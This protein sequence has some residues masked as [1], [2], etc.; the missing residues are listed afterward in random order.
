M[1]DD[2]NIVKFQPL[3]RYQYPSMPT[4]ENLRLW[5]GKLWRSFREPDDDPL[6]ADNS[7]QWATEQRLDRIAPPPAC[8]PLLRELEATFQE[9][10]SEPNPSHWTQL[11]VV[12]PCDAYDILGAWA[13]RY[14]HEVIEPP[15]RE[16]L[17]SNLVDRAP[18]AFDSDGVIVIPRLERWFIRHHNGLNLVRELLSQLAVLKRH[19]V[20][21][22]NSWAWRFLEKSIDAELILP[23]GMT[24]QAFD[25][26]RLRDW[27]VETAAE[28]GVDDLTFR[29][30]KD[31][32]D[33]LEF[34][35][36][37]QPKSEFLAVLAAKSFGIPWV[38]WHVW[39]S[40]LRVVPEER[41]QIKQR[42]PNE[43]TVWVAS[44]ADFTLPSAQ[45]ASALLILHALLI[46]GTMRADELQLALPSIV[47]SNLL[48]GLVISGVVKRDDDTFA[49]SPVAYPMVRRALASAGYPLDRL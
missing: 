9:W 45:A 12:P 38:A 10:V 13:D 39:R 42:F 49:C 4:E 27:F 8:G 22:C 48:S 21:G 23:T 29:L 32:Q 3:G 18:A 16:Q 5:S 33:V 1:T 30:S 34:T 35:D 6:V 43:R 47:S 44:P 2:S 11:V 25:A 17:F 15:D 46:H 40:C 36:N 31:G 41:E 20:I 14:G 37:G 28:S 19:C 26:K 7:L 24:G